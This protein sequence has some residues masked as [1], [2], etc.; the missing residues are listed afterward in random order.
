MIY[1]IKNI[2]KAA[3]SYEVVRCSNCW[4]YYYDEIIDERNNNS[5]KF[6]WDKETEEFY[7]GCPQ[8]KTDDYLADIDEKQLTEI[9][10][11]SQR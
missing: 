6:I 10:S 8:C 1:G 11:N 5:L 3:E 4:T 2:S 9:Q 7:K